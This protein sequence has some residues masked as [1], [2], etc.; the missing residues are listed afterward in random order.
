M[1]KLSEKSEQGAAVIGSMLGEQHAEKMKETA[2]S[3]KFG[4]TISRMA[5]DYAFADAWGREG[6][7][8]REKSLL[9]ISALIALRQTHEL[10][11]HVKIGVTN[12]LTIEDFDRILVQLTPYL[13]FPCIATATTAVIEALREAGKDPMVQTSEEKGLL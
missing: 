10:K 9:I 12:G 5:L 6:L 1:T 11:N 8:R 3:G 4:S 13:G 7:P 2:V